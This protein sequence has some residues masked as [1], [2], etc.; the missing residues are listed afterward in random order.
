[1]APWPMAGRL[2]VGVHARADT[3]LEPQAD[4]AG[5][6][7]DDGVVVPGVELGQPGVDVAAQGL[8][9][10]VWP[11]HRELALTAQAGGADPPAIGQGVEGCVAVG[12]EGVEG[13]LALQDHRQM[14]SAREVHRHVLHGMDRDVGLAREHPLLELLHEEPLATYLRERGVEDPVALGGHAQDLHLQA[15]MGGAQPLRDMLGLPHGEG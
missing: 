7:Q 4:Q 13:V 8:D 9:H 6:R 2:S 15:R 10:E 14:Q 1:M 3:A 11:A 5:R 12:H